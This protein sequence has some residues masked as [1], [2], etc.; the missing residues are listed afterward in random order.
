MCLGGGGIGDSRTR[1]LGGIYQPG[2][3]ESFGASARIMAWGPDV[4]WLADG[5]PPAV[6]LC[7]S[8]VLL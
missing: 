5:R 2:C 7:S 6:C 3:S 4:K 1:E 8:T